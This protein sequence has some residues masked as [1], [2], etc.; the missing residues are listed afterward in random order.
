MKRCRKIQKD[1]ERYLDGELLPEKIH[2]F[3]EHLRTCG[4]CRRALEEKREQRR[5][6]VMH[7]MPEEIPITTDEIMEVIQGENPAEFSAEI[8]PFPQKVSWLQRF[9][10]FAFRPAPAIALALCIIALSLSIFLPFGSHKNFKPGI[11]I[12][13]IESTRSYMIYQPE[14]S[15]TTVIW[16]VPLEKKKEA[17]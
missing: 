11:V 15:D 3:E 7:L 4:K 8:V 10:T 13:K 9:K 14:Q 2:T 17:T 12:E 6:R 1:M 5:M 16:I